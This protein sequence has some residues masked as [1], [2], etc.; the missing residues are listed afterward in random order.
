[1][2][3]TLNLTKPVPITKLLKETYGGN[4]KY[5]VKDTVWINLDNKDE[6]ACYVSNCSCDDVCGCGSS[7]YLYGRGTPIRVKFRD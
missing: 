6:R 7:F 3:L 1:M 5:L 2:K 4:W